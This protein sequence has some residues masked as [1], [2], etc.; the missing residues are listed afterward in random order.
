MLNA[1]SDKRQAVF[2]R[3]PPVFFQKRYMLSGKRSYVF[4]VKPVSC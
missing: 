2:S 4:W 1:Y 3:R